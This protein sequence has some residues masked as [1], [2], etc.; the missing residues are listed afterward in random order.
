MK[1]YNLIR[2]CCI[3]ELAIVGFISIACL[4]DNSIY[5]IFYNLIYGIV[6]SVSVPLL[7][8]KKERKPLR[9]VGVKKIRQTSDCRIIFFCI[10]FSWRAGDT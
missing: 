5:Y 9:E 10:V 2:L 1:K 4:F 3:L 6:I 8:L 7:I